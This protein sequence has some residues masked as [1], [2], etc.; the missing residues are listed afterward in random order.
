MMR[1]TPSVKSLCAFYA[2]L[3]L[4][5]LAANLLSGP[6]LVF[7]QTI[8]RGPYLQLG[9]SSGIVV[10]WRT[11]VATDS[12]VEFGSAPASLTNSMIS[13]T[14]TTEHVI[15]LTGLSADALYY[16]SVGSTTQVLAG[17]DTS[18]F[19]VTAPTPGTA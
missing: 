9:T 7:A 15:T 18:H 11:S 3:G 16:Y 8:T 17:A 2:R 5:F 10:R 14:L 13:P 1:R 6:A 12:R 4:L 19:F